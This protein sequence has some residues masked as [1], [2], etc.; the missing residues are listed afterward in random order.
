[1]GGARRFGRLL[2]RRGR[3]R[4]RFGGVRS[5]KLYQTA[6]PSRF[7]E[8]RWPSG[9]DSAVGLFFRPAFL[10]S[11]AAPGATPPVRAGEAS[12]PVSLHSDSPQRS[13]DDDSARMIIKRSDSPLRSAA[14]ACGG[15]AG[16]GYANPSQS[17]RL[18]HVIGW[19]PYG[20]QPGP[21]RPE[22]RDDSV[23]P[24]QPG[25]DRRSGAWLQVTPKAGQPRRSSL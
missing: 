19:R 2:R 20:R 12:P 17:D 13:D 16:P 1:V 23:D 4:R 5:E 15:S 8:R 3:R 24:G 22:C 9:H 25:G 21:G 10:A 7:L 6:P 14:R 18:G 11:A